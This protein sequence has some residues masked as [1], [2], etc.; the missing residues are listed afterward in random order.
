VSHRKRAPEKGN[1]VN[2]GKKK[3]TAGPRGIKE[4]REGRPPRSEGKKKQTEILKKKHGGKKV[5]ENA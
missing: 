4:R 1:F 3:T 5:P 2:N